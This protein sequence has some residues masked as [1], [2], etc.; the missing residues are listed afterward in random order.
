MS[1]HEVAGIAQT[2][3]SIAGHTN[4]TRVAFHPEP[5]S[6]TFGEHCSGD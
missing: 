5:F 6:A 4:Q 1:P 3:V 2:A